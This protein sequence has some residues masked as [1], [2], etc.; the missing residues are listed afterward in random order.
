M[1]GTTVFY[2]GIFLQDCETLEFRQ[3]IEMDE[4]NTDHL[5]SRFRIRVASTLC[6][7]I[8]PEILNGLTVATA[9]ELAVLRDN[10]RPDHGSIITPM[11]FVTT[12]ADATSSAHLEHNQTN[13]SL[14]DIS[15]AEHHLVIT[16]FLKEPRKD[17]WMSISAQDN[18]DDT[19]MAT[20]VPI[21]PPDE[22]DAG[23]GP[24]RFSDLSVLA[25]TGMTEAE[26]LALDPLAMTAGNAKYL[27]ASQILRYFCMDTANGP[28]PRSVT[29]QKIIGGRT[30]RIEFEIE[31]CVFVGP[32]STSTAIKD[33]QEAAYR[34]IGAR[35]T[36]GVASNRWSVT[37]SLDENWKTTHAIK[38]Q[39]VVRDHT[40][41]AH[42]QRML[43]VPWMFPYAKMT[44]REFYTDPTGLTLNYQHTFTECGDAPPYGVVNWKGDY[45][46]QV[47][48]GGKSI[49]SVS[50]RV[51]GTIAPPKG[52]TA[53]QYKKLLITQGFRMILSRIPFSLR[54]DAAAP[55]PGA[56]A[57]NA[58]LQDAVVSEHMHEPI[59]DIRAVVLHKTK[60]NDDDQTEALNEF[61]LRLTKMGDPIIST[62]AEPPFGD[63][64]YN[65]LWWPIPSSFTW[66][67]K[68]VR[69]L[70][71][72]AEA[73]SKPGS[74]FDCYFQSPEYEWHGIP[75][76][77]DI[78]D[79]IDANPA[80]HPYIR[81]SDSA[82]DN[83]FEEYLDFNFR[84]YGGDGRPLP[85][86]EH[87]DASL[88]APQ[89]KYSLINKAN[90]LGGFS[91]LT[92]D[93][94]TTVNHGN[95]VVMLP[96]SKAR[97]SVGSLAFVQPTDSGS[98]PV[99]S[100]TAKDTAV[101]V[102]LHAPMSYREYTVIA[103]R[104]GDW[105][106]VPQPKQS[107][108]SPTGGSETLLTQETVA[109]TPKP[110]PDDNTMIY[111]IE[112]RWRYA[113]SRPPGYASQFQGEPLSLPNA[114][115]SSGDRSVIEVGANPMYRAT[116]G[117]NQLPLAGF[118]DQTNGQYTT[119]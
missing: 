30:M 76:G 104:Q 110:G 28:K 46:E 41:K 91:Y 94:K 55:K 108:L 61:G 1:A 11:P 107:I 97:D 7:T 34:D 4:S 100:T 56:L 60:D 80:S 111:G 116:P 83:Y 109:M 86:G 85:E 87:A 95:G 112:C 54:V 42:A 84:G 68:T 99:I 74:Y 52:L 35:K 51:V 118:Y 13:A 2:N 58:V 102:R 72:A 5:W 45:S 17:F 115:G 101:S 37:E 70:Q 117:D 50:V 9:R 69:N 88:P 79:R 71:T 20:N 57:T 105:P 75:V 40:F 63:P 119:V 21:G 78:P 59:V 90:Q 53:S 96:L 18:S 73:G 81:G 47:L 25:A 19:S 10:E 15:L 14:Q 113:M 62:T 16:K 92:Y 64:N 38:G 43:T 12:S 32:F 77:M 6:R 89:N 26:A 3:V 29:V 24:R 82:G 8:K 39:L 98:E 66:D 27:Q 44:R 93:A 106:K 103:T 65:R 22:A 31:I 36:I 33:F 49:G 114:S 48:G 23:G 67:W